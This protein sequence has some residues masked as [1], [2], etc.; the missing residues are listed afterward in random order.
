MIF[1]DQ[2]TDDG[3]WCETILLQR[4][5]FCCWLFKVQRNP[6]ESSSFLN[7]FPSYFYRY[8]KRFKIVKEKI[9]ANWCRQILRGLHFL[10]TRLPA[11]IHRDLKCDNIFITGTTGLLKLGDLGLATFKKASFVKSVIGKRLST[12]NSFEDSFEIVF[13][14]WYDFLSKICLFHSIWTKDLQKQTFF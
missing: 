8:I 11:I 2:I 13:D 1:N 4:C 9:L 14:I 5:G 6:R 7:I 3:S 10:H 12:Y